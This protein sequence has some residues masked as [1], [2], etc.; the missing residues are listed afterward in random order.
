MIYCGT[1]SFY[2]FYDSRIW[3]G[4]CWISF[5]R[6]KELN[7]FKEIT[8]IYILVSALLGLKGNVEMTLAS[9]LSTQ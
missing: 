9:R 8:E 1:T 5:E 4:C 6:V 2:S 3:Y 7:I